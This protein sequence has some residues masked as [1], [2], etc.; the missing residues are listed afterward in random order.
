MQFLRCTSHCTS[1]WDPGPR[2]GGNLGSSWRPIQSMG[3]CW[4]QSVRFL[5]SNQY[6]EGLSGCQFVS[7]GPSRG[8]NL[9]CSWLVTWKWPT[10]IPSLQASGLHPPPSAVIMSKRGRK[11]M[12]QPLHG[13]ILLLHLSRVD[14]GLLVAGQLHLSPLQSQQEQSG[15]SEKL[16]TFH[17]FIGSILKTPKTWWPCHRWCECTGRQ[18]GS[19]PL[20]TKVTAVPSEL[21]HYTHTHKI[22]PTKSHTHWKNHTHTDKVRQQAHTYIQIDKHCHLHRKYNSLFKTFVSKPQLMINIKCF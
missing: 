17:V 19:S 1:Y 18:A 10:L 9:W 6:K 15:Q 5:Q 8:A 3:H 14:A 13:I 4:C 12:Q 22:T 2:R 7:K 20:G 16:H 21:S 11:S